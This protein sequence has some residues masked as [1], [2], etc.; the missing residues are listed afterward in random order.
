MAMS[1]T[2]FENK[3]WKFVAEGDLVQKSVLTLCTSDIPVKNNKTGINI[4]AGEIIETMLEL[5][6]LRV[7]FKRIEL[8]QEL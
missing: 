8:I 5:S 4:T 2:E 6:Q 1:R 3:F 7:T